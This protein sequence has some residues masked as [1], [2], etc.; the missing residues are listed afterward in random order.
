VGELGHLPFEPEAAHLLF[1]LVPR[2]HERGAM[3]VTGNR[4]AVERGTVFGDPVVAT[5]VLDRPLHHSHVIAIR[6]DGCRPRE[7]RRSGLVKAAPPG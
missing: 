2:R 6:G 4:P 7:K 3:L 5:A 1:R